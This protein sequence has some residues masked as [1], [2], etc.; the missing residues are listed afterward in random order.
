IKDGRVRRAHMGI[1]AQP[2]P[3][4]RR[5]V[6]DLRL[7]AET[8]VQIMNVLPG[9]PAQEAGLLRGDIVLAVEGTTIADVDDLH[10]YLTRNH[11]ERASTVRILRGSE[12]QE[13]PIRLREV[14][15]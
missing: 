12:V 10:R 1:E 6:H 15:E 3:L 2:R 13:V 8:G 11:E 4:P 7:S 5:L 9:G 14:R